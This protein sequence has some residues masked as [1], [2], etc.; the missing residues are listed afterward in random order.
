MIETLTLE[1]LLEKEKLPEKSN[2]KTCVQKRG[3]FGRL[4]VRFSP[5]PSAK[6]VV[7]RRKRPKERRERQR[8]GAWAAR[9]GPAWGPQGHPPSPARS[10]LT[11]HYA[12]ALLMAEA[13]NSSPRAPFRALFSEH[14]SQSQRQLGGRPALAQKAPIKWERAPLIDNT[15]YKKKN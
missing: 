8:Q 11:I 3:G 12:A 2:P 15:F 14:L 4:P 10:D 13:F 9:R 1:S 5:P 6:H 7:F